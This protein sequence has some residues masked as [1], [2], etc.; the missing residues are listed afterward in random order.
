[1]P[2]AVGRRF[3]PDAQLLCSPVD[4]AEACASI[5]CGSLCLVNTIQ[6]CRYPALCCRCRPDPDLVLD[7]LCPRSLLHQ[8]LFKFMDMFLEEGG[9][10]DPP[11][12]Q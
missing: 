10:Q 3:D 12:R 5:G 4:I 7:A 6:G 8:L 11:Q 9:V 2:A 1:M